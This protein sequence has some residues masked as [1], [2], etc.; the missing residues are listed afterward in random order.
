MTEE[1]ELDERMRQLGLTLTFGP[2]TAADVPRALELLRRTNQFNTTGLLPDKSQLLRMTQAVSGHSVF[3]AH[4]R[5]RFGDFGLVGVIVVRHGDLPSI[6]SFVMSCRAMGYGAEQIILDLVISR[7]GMPLS[8]RLV[9]TRL[10]EPCHGLYA[11]AGFIEKEPGYWLVT[12]GQAGRLPNW[13][14]VLVDAPSPPDPVAEIL[15]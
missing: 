4:L 2:M 9:H 5:D 13:F 8:A 15:I 1:N 7:F 14:D 12:V 3:T 6:E 11:S 10:N